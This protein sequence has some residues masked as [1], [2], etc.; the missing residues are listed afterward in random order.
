M[1]FNLRQTAVAVLLTSAFVGGASLAVSA[2]SSTTE[3]TP[4]VDDA[5]TEA[6]TPKPRPDA[7]IE[8]AG[9]K[10]TPQECYQDCLAANPNAKA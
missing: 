2:C 1:S 5:G 8:D 9:K 6:A 3:T 10:K 7:A 4:G